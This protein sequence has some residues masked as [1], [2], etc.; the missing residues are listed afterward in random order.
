[1]VFA[2]AWVK[3]DQLA[4]LESF[5]LTDNIGAAGWRRETSAREE[6]RSEGFGAGIL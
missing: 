2:L 1:M 4:R 5:G 3:Q 6:S